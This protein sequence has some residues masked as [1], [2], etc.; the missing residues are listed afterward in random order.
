M[1]LTDHQIESSRRD[2]E[3][4]GAENCHERDEQPVRG[5]ELG[6]EAGDVVG[7]RQVLD[8]LND[9]TG[10]AKLVSS[11]PGVG[12]TGAWS[13]PA[14]AGGRVS[15]ARDHPPEPV[16]VGVLVAKADGA[17]CELGG[18]WVAAEHTEPKSMW[19]AAAVDVELETPTRQERTAA[20]GK[21]QD[22]RLP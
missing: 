17:V 13:P 16:L 6:F 9:R 1:S 22:Q 2:G 15:G 20:S 19:P 14:A 10:A 3:H 21:P 4:G 5:V 8:L 18:G 7:R 11:G 12:R